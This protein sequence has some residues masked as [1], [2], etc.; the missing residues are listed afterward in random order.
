LWLRHLRFGFPG[1][2]GHHTGAYTYVAQMW[3]SS[4]EAYSFLPID[5]NGERVTAELGSFGANLA[6]AIRQNVWGKYP[7][8]LSQERQD[9]LLGRIRGL[10]SV[11]VIGIG[12]RRAGLAVGGGHHRC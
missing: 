4:V 7:V 11:S 8:M 1:P 3:S 12:T 5:C 6:R 2:P 10:T 9:E